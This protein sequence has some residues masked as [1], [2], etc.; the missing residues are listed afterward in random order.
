MC[1]EPAVK[2]SPGVYDRKNGSFEK[3][4]NL[5]FVPVFYLRPIWNGCWF[6][7]KRIL[8]RTLEK[9][10]HVLR[11][12]HSI[13]VHSPCHLN[14][15]ETLNL[16]FK[17]ILECSQ[18]S[19]ASGGHDTPHP[20][21]LSGISP[22]RAIF[23]LY[24]NI[25]FQPEIFRCSQLPPVTITP[26]PP[27]L[28][29]A[30]LAVWKMRPLGP[31]SRSDVSP[32]CHIGRAPEMLLCFWGDPKATLSPLL[33]EFS[34]GTSWDQATVWLLSQTSTHQPGPAGASKLSQP[35]EGCQRVTV[36]II[37]STLASRFSPEKRASL[38]PYLFSI[39]IDSQITDLFN[40][41]QCF[42]RKLMVFRNQDLGSLLLGLWWLTGS[43]RGKRLVIQVGMTH[44][45]GCT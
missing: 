13:P 27:Q 14:E 18:I 1:L 23:L 3:A 45:W 32:W 30:V 29:Q 26:S 31:Q 33:L 5:L 39:A 12:S 6:K 37:P 43:L 11:I 35:H 36:S 20:W 21:I 24:K 22:N 10:N 7:A 38:L 41:Y 42:F 17:C 34:K 44:V 16:E 25:T 15:W 8:N 28:P 2:N 9:T 19:R 4:G 40:V